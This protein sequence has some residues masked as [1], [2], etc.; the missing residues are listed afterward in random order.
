[1]SA[2]GI[3]HLPTREARQLA[4]LDIAKAKRQGYATIVENTTA[5]TAT[6]V[7]SPPPVLPE[8]LYG[9]IKIT[10]NDVGA[11]YLQ[12]QASLPT[13]TNQLT[14][15]TR[16]TIDWDGRP[17]NTVADIA[18]PLIDFPGNPY[19]GDPGF[20][21]TVITTTEL[22]GNSEG[23][24]IEALHIPNG[25]FSGSGVPN[26]SAPYYRGRNVLEITQLPNP[27][28][29]N[30]IDPDE[31]PNV[32]GLVVGRPWVTA[33]ENSLV[34]NGLVLHYD[35]SNPACYTSGTTVTDLSTSTNNGT[36]VNESGNVSYVSDGQTSYFNWSSNQGANGLG[37]CIS[38]SD[39]ETYKDFTMVFMPNFGEGFGG[40]FAMTADQSLRVYNGL[41]WGFPNPGNGN[42][43]AHPSATTFYINGQATTSDLPPAVAG[44]NIMGGAKTSPNFPEP[45]NLYIGTSGYDNRHMQGRIAVV[46]MY[47]RALTQEEQLQ[48][49]NSLKTRF[50]L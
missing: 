16:I 6:F 32:G 19:P 13:I 7:F 46:L 20:L 29:D 50:G 45:S 34:T 40:L 24:N 15:G 4:K 41:T 22:P 36:V 33:P 11:V 3:A 49:Y 35:F 1:M 26:T 12:F 27:Y 14:V 44:W 17:G 23:Y 38:V 43:W 25:R 18:G 48:N 21:L 5:Y 10:V 31:N 2:N 8:F 28:N 9:K 42:D 47:N 37:S 30:D 39:Q